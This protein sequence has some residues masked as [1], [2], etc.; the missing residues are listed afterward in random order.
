[1]RVKR[2]ADLRFLA[3]GIVVSLLLISCASKEAQEISLSD[4]RLKSLQGEEI[5]LDKYQGK[6]VFINVWATWCKPCVQEMPTI[7]TAM[8]QL[9]GTDV[10]FL[11]ASAEEAEEIANFRNARRFPFEYVQLLNLEALHIQALPTTFIFD[12][13]GEL[14]YGE[15]GFRDWSTQENLERIKPLVE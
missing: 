8:K 2:F 13:D 11:F 1:M 12:A 14:V 9:E 3:S 10:V 5:D 15:E 6:R 4:F 7:A